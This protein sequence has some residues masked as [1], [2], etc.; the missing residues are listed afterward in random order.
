MVPLGTRG[1]SSPVWRNADET[2]EVSPSLHQPSS[3][4][5]LSAPHFRSQKWQSARI[6]WASSTFKFMKLLS[7]TGNGPGISL[8]ESV[9]LTN[10][11]NSFESSSCTFQRSSVD[12]SR[13]TSHGC[14]LAKRYFAVSSCSMIFRYLESLRT[15][16]G[17]LHT[18]FA[19]GLMSRHITLQQLQ[20]YNKRAV[21]K[22][23][24]FTPW[25]L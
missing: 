24:K 23:E 22:E 3:S 17:S 1:A 8:L 7:R 25:T 14:A 9:P 16:S 18:R 13:A 5:V 12:E 21:R 6:R 15:T 2:L 4:R 19:S 10:C 11:V 20:S